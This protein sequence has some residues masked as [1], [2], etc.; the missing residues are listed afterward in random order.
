MINL[1]TVKTVTVTTAVLFLSASAA[2]AAMMAARGEEDI[3][4]ALHLARLAGCL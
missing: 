2:Y 4:L 3:W 1:K